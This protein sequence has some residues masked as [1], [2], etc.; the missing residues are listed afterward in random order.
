MDLND[1]L[2]FIKVVEEGSF[3]KAGIA[4]G[5]PNSTVSHKVSSLE[6]RLGVTLIKRTTRK[7]IIT[8]IGMEY[9]QKAQKGINEIFDSEKIIF[10]SKNEPEGLLR[11]TA[12][13]ELGNYI[14][15]NVMAKFLKKYP[16]VKIEIVYTDRVLN[17][18]EDKVDLAIRTGDLKDSS[19]KSKKIGFNTFALYA[20]PQYLK[21]NSPIKNPSDLTEHN[22]IQFLPFGRNEWKLKS[23]KGTATIKLSGEFLYS[24]LNM[25][26]GLVVNHLGVAALPTYLCVNEVK[27]KKLV[28]ILGEWNS[29]FVPVSFVY[30]AGKYVPKVLSEFINF[31]FE[32][33]KKKLETCLS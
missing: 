20:S 16:K 27:E 19:F 7:L 13:P 23:M 12:P 1:V 28:K 21:E 2:V 31:S 24:D 26:K 4:L 18:L 22:C 10:Q 33:I 25:V 8:P 30:P 17:L 15:P 11:L 6:A 5:M 9:F 3:S 14:L 29:H 32:E